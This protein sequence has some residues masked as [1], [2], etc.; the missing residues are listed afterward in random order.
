M[1]KNILVPTDGS[2]FSQSTVTRA[3]S[4]AKE[5]GARITALTVKPP[6]TEVFWGKGAYV[7]LPTAEAIE[8]M[9]EQEA[10]E[11]V[12]GVEKSCQEAGVPCIRLTKTSGSI[13]QAIIDAAVDSQC[14]LIFM[15]SHGRRGLDALILGSETN[16]VLTHSTIP[17]LVFR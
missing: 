16:K 4:F 7:H 11:I 10:Q 15:A 6:H 9:A 14:D 5:A 13:H 1:F 3:I 12:A 8:Q 2:E 17:V